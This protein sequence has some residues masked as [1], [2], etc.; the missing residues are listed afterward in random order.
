VCATQINS[1]LL[2]LHFFFSLSDKIF[3]KVFFPLK[4]KIALL[5]VGDRVH[6]HR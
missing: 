4:T 1:T 2:A 3:L 6:E 5:A